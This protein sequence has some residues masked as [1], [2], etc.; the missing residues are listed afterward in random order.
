[1]YIIPH[2][3]G[4]SNTL[5]DVPV[6]RAQDDFTETMKFLRMHRAKDES[7]SFYYTKLK[8]QAS[9]CSIRYSQDWAIRDRLVQSI[10]N[11]D[12]L[13]ELAGIISPSTKDV[14]DASQKIEKVS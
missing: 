10:T 1:M 6:K 3:K 8:Q 14:L 2:R 4:D 13:N 7:I 5:P 12:V 9:K 11:E